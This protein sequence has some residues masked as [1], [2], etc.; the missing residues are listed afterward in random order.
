MVSRPGRPVNVS[1][2]F[3]GNDVCRVCRAYDVTE[4]G[5]LVFEQLKFNK[6]YSILA[7]LGVTIVKI[8]KI[9]NIFS[10]VNV[11]MIFFNSL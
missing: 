9:I 1:T 5:S 6:L 8:V 10:E 3:T 4:C 7:D 2:D 11:G